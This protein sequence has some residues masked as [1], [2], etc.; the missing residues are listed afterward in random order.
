[1]RIHNLGPHTFVT[2]S[3]HPRHHV[4]LTKFTP[5]QRR[6]LIEEDAQAK[7]QT[8]A[9]IGTAMASGIVLLAAALFFIA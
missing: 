3:V 6:E 8:A 4:W 7:W 9:V 1:M 5:R 2:E